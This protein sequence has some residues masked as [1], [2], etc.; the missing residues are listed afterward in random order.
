MKQLFTLLLCALIL[1]T[2][3]CGGTEKPDGM[4]PLH[5][6]TLTF[7]QDGKPLAE[8]SVT[9]SPQDAANT[10]WSLGGATDSNGVLKVQTQGF[11]GAPEGTYKIVV[12]K[13]ETEG[14]GAPV[15]SSDDAS[16]KPSAAGS[17][18]KSFY[19]VDKKY[20]SVGTTDLTLEVKAGKNAQTIDLGSAVREE[21][22]VHKN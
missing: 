16:V 18:P 8:A 9:L 19:L 22:P 2:I 3:G 1:S 14:A 21:I 10:Q 17:V 7:T 13:T 20:R 15:E 11:D 4:P 12:T 6:T 5:Q